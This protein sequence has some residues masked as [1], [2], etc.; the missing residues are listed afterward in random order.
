[1]NGGVAV[2]RPV[3]ALSVPESPRR[4]VST[5]RASP[6]TTRSPASVVGKMMPVSKKLLLSC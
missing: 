4:G 1:M 6:P 2:A 5:T 3:E